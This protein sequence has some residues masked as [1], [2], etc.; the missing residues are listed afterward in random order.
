[1]IDLSSSSDEEDLIAATS[2][3]FEF[4]QRLFSELNSTVLG[5]HNDSKIIIL[6]DSDEEEVCEEKTT[7]IEDA[8]ASIAV[9]PA[10]TASA[11]ADNVPVGAK[12]IIV[13]IRALIR[14]LTATPA[15]DVTPASLRLPHQE[16]AEAGVLQEELQWFYIAVPSF[17]CA[18]K[19]G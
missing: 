9:N 15:A 14:R 11:N 4:A 10:S 12:M 7:V 2:H 6:S 18:E 3:D 8:A 5:P 1:V 16:G 17:L 19:L 13:M